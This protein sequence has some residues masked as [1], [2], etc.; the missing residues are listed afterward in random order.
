MTRS[1]CRARSRRQGKAC[2]RPDPQI[3]LVP[4]GGVNIDTTPEFL[5]AGAV[6]LCAGGALVSKQAVAEGRFDIVTET[7]R[8]FREVID[9]TRDE[10]AG[11]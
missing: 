2:K 4:T 1:S 5:K 3:R 6:A 7:A 11:G 10:M 9:R 8:R